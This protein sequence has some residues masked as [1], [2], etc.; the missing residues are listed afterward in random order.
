M[1]NSGSEQATPIP[2]EVDNREWSWIGNTLR[3]PEISIKKRTFTWN[4]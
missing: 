1:N 3:K 4:P 2:Q